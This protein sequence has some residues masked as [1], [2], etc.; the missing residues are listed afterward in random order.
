MVYAKMNN[1]VQDNRQASVTTET[2]GVES[3]LDIVDEIYEE[4]LL[5]QSKGAVQCS[6]LQEQFYRWGNAGPGGKVSPAGAGAA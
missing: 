4:G 1:H 5:Q 2:P 6:V 3:L